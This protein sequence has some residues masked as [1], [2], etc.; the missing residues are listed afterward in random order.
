MTATETLLD[1][2]LR[3][4]PDRTARHQFHHQIARLERE[5]AETLARLDVTHRPSGRP[6]E[7]TSAPRMLTGAE[8]EATRDALVARLAEARN[9]VAGQRSD[10]TEARALLKRM[11]DAPAEFRWTTITTKDLGVEGCKSWQ[12]VPVLGPVGMLGN[13]WRIRMSSGCP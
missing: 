4:A 11:S 6:R 7:G 3:L 12:S 1:L 5:L 2:D 13:W 10:R 9:L 8:L